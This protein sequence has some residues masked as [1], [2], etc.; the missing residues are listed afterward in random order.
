MLSKNNCRVVFT[1]DGNI[2]IC[3]LFNLQFQLLLMEDVVFL[4][5]HCS[6]VR[7]KAQTFHMPISESVQAKRQEK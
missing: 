1:L 2:V 7:L 6:N 3:E 5:S 4:N